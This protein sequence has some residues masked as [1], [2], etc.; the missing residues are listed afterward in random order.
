MDD[1]KW[2]DEDDGNR[3]VRG[4]FTDI[5]R[6]IDDIKAVML[7]NIRAATDRGDAIGRLAL[8]SDAV[9][10]DAKVFGGATH[11]VHRKIYMRN[12]KLRIVILIV[13]CCGIATLLLILVVV[14]V[15]II[16]ALQNSGVLFNLAHSKS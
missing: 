10:E 6:R 11:S 14:F 9:E 12:I 7:D 15:A 1:A 3:D 16:I 8:E 4:R 5:D 2:L 13:C